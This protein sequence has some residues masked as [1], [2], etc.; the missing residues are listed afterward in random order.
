MRQIPGTSG[1]FLSRL[2]IEDDEFDAIARCLLQSFALYPASPTAIDIELLTEKLF[3]HCGYQF[4]DLPDEL[5]GRVTFSPKGPVFIE[6]HRHLDAFRNRLLNQRCRST[7]AHEC[8]HCILH[9]QLFTALWQARA[10]RFPHVSEG[11]VLKDRTRNLD[12]SGRSIDPETWFEYQANRLMASLLLP[13]HSVIN[14]IGHEYLEIDRQKRLTYGD[15]RQ[16]A[17][18][19]ADTFDVSPSLAQYRL[20]DI[21]GKVLPRIN[22]L[23]IT[24]QPNT[25]HTL[26]D[27]CFPAEV[28]AELRVA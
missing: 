27:F 3:P 1:R 23:H 20:K 18:R 22:R 5:M 8:S 16:L 2:W 15:K 24:G 6:I 28:F 21:F 12:E 11:V 26:P 13:V 10:R 9:T 14:R 17:L 4:T 19:L 25:Y 7:I